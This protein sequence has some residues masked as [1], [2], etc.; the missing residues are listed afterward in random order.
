MLIDLTQHSVEI[1]PHVAPTI[2]VVRA[3]DTASFRGE[4]EFT[5]QFSPSY[6]QEPLRLAP[7]ASGPAGNVKIFYEPGGG[8]HTDGTGCL[9]EWKIMKP[10][11]YWIGSARWEF[12]QPTNDQSGI[13]YRASQ[14]ILSQLDTFVDSVGFSNVTM[15]DLVT[16]LQRIDNNPTDHFRIHL[17]DYNPNSAE[18]TPLSRKVAVTPRSVWE[19]LDDIP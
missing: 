3:M 14:I 17:S 1:L 8:Y 6:V 2:L 18:P 10:G 13:K 11:S 4:V 7:N 9:M 5:P 12:P 19:R 16:E 15:I